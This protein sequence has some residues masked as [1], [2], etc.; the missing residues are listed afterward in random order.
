M[1]IS[2]WSSDVC[3]SDLLVNVSDR[4]HAFLADRFGKAARMREWPV[5]AEEGLQVISGR[6]DLLI[7]LGDG[8]AIV[9]HKSFPGSVEMDD[10]RLS[11]FAGQVG[12]SARTIEWITGRSEDRWVGKEGGSTGK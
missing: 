2:D 5:H 10:D 3:S 12:L 7:D 6:L 11:A 4:L 9:D 1:R 8:F